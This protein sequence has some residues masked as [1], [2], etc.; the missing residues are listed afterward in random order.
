MHCQRQ[1]LSLRNKI[2]VDELMFVATSPNRNRPAFPDASDCWTC[3]DQTSNL[4]PRNPAFDVSNSPTAPEEIGFFGGEGFVELIWNPHCCQKCII[5]LDMFSK[6]W[7]K[8]IPNGLT[9]HMFLPSQCE[10]KSSM[11]RCLQPFVDCYRLAWWT[12]SNMSWFNRIGSLHND[13]AKCSS[14]RN[15]WR[16]QSNEFEIKRILVT[17]DAW[18][19]TVH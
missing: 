15:Q 5:I 11:W 18:H 12:M 13:W 9:G 8:S 7:S 17:F 1:I 16:R 3:W 4:L 14:H 19:A 6:I 10:L 2:I